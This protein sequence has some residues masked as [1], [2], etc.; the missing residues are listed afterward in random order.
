[1]PLAQIDRVTN[2][3]IAGLGG[4]G[5]LTAAAVLAETAFRAG[6]DVKRS[7]L[8][9]MSQ[10]GGSVCSCVRF[11]AKIF[12]PMIPHGE[13]DFL[14]LMAP[15]EIE[16]YRGELRSAEGIITADMFAP[17]DLPRRQC[18]NAAM[19]GALSLRLPF[20]PATWVEAFSAFF[21]RELAEVNTGAFNIGR[22]KMRRRMGTQPA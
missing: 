3:K 18:L 8:H 7:E 15:G 10:R 13:T 16:L 11:G 9:G 17:E 4:M 5:V 2:V 19:L 6:R 20:P 21:K 14:L 1:M 12:S 22:D